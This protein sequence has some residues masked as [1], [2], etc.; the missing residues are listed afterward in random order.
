MKNDFNL[1]KSPNLTQITDRLMKASLK[2]QFKFSIE[3]TPG[4]YVN[5][6]VIQVMA[7]QNVT[8]DLTGNTLY[9][10]AVS[11]GSIDE[12]AATTVIQTSSDDNPLL[13]IG[14]CFDR[15]KNSMAINCLTFTFCSNYGQDIKCYL[16]SKRIDMKQTGIKRNTLCNTYSMAYLNAF[17]R[18]NGQIIGGSGD[19]SLSTTTANLCA[20]ECISNSDMDCRG[21]EFCQDGMCY[22]RQSH[23]IDINPNQKPAPGDVKCVF[24]SSKKTQFNNLLINFV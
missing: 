8:S 9:Y 11:G 7:S 5:Y 12:N 3:T 17:K 18:I 16:T 2:N 1:T 20:K 6:S 21:F 14:D 13:S 24:Y 22:L 4:K 19:K 23:T 15:C 10:L